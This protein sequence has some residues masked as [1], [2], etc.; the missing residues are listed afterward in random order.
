[1][2]PNALNPSVITPP[3]SEPEYAPISSVDTLLQELEQGIKFSKEYAASLVKAFGNE[4]LKD[5][6]LGRYG[7]I[8][9]QEAPLSCARTPEWD[10]KIPKS[11]PVESRPP[12][13][14]P[15][16][17]PPKPHEH[18][19]I[20]PH[21]WMDTPNGIALTFDDYPCALMTLDQNPYNPT[22]LRIAQLQNITYYY[23]QEY[24]NEAGQIADIRTSTP[25]F[26]APK[27]TNA[28]NYPRLFVSLAEDLA[29]HHG[30]K[31]IQIPRASNISWV[32]RAV[33]PLARAEQ[34][35]DETARAMGY[36]DAPGA[37][38]DF[39]KTL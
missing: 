20:Q 18:F 7:L 31:E 4:Q 5:K 29:R 15:D 32:K 14:T 34:I 10:F 22:T 12:Q 23:H 2:S 21:I 25:A 30:V 27:G 3:H 1:M 24:I 39:Y 17:V 13:L 38:F 16:Q 6:N 28:V 36:S 37:P 8:A 11:I 19:S 26:R 9:I 35:Y 33:M